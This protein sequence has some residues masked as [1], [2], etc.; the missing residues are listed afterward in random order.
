MTEAA[1]TNLAQ[2]IGVNGSV[3]VAPFCSCSVAIKLV[4]RQMAGKRRRI[5]HEL[6]GT[7]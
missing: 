5:L 4:Q 7:V 6:L 3:A 1:M 2:D